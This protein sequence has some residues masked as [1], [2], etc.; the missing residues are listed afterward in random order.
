[1]TNKGQ[2]ALDSFPFC[3]DFALTDKYAIFFIGSIV[4][5]GMAGV[6]LGA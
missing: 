2:V 6:M 1:M 5:S 3:H 4:F